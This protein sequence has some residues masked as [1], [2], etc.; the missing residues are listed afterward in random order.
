MTTLTETLD[1]RI[2]R[3]AAEAPPLAARQLA[4]ITGALRPERLAQ[5]A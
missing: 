5:A 1:A 3:L 2:N 4:V